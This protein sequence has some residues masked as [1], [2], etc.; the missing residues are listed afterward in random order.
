MRRIALLFLLFAAAWLLAPAATAAAKPTPASPNYM[1]TG[2]QGAMALIHPGYKSS[3]AAQI[4]TTGDGSGGLATWGAVD[5]VIPSTLHFGQI[6]TLITEYRFELGSCWGGSPRFEAW[7]PDASSP[8][9]H[10][11]VFFY[12]G[13]P[14]DYTDC[15]LGVWAS[16]GNLAAPASYVD[17][18]QLPG[19][20]FYDTVAHADQVYGSDPV[21]AVYLDADGGWEATQ[22]IDFDNTQV[23][24]SLVTY[25]K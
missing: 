6:T 2:S 10:D 20:T 5:V 21:S 12:I 25:E 15:A 8:T 24:G 3:T 7:I 18:S 4:T 19:G 17:D 9:G 22:T 13:A 16:T 1:F 23:D 11:K 14:P